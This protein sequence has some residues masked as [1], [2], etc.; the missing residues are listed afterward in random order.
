MF[1]GQCRRSEDSGGP[2]TAG[3]DQRRLLSLAPHRNE[4][5]PNGMPHRCDALGQGAC[6]SRATAPI[7]PVNPSIEGAHPCGDQ[8]PDRRS[9]DKDLVVRADPAKSGTDCINL[10][11]S[12]GAEYLPVACSMT[13][14]PSDQ[15]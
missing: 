7:D 2:S 13:P 11:L 3:H 5:Q 12:I 8:P 6:A 1:D 14:R 9:L 10:R 15:P 4:A